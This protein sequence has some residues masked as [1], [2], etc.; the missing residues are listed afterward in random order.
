MATIKQI[1]ANRLNAQR[2]TGPCSAEGKAVSSMNAL[3]SGIDAE[4]QIIRGEDPAALA[5]LT[6]EY[7]DRFQPTTPEQRHYLDTLIRDDWQLRRFAKVDAQIWEYERETAFRPD[8]NSPL[9]QAF[10]EASST[11]VRLQRRMDAAQRSYKNA[12]HEL[13][14][15]QSAPEPAP[16]PVAKQP[17]S[18]AIGFVPQTPADAPALHLV[19]P[20]LPCETPIPDLS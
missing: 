12:L 16:Q 2:S 14:R 17:T 15:L 3:K 5:T 9:G 18:P 19:P 7:Y 20:T 10:A 6:S 11:F 4:S 13:E 1:E 8:E